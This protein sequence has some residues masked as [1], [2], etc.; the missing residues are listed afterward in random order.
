[1]FRFRWAVCQLDEIAKCINIKQLRTTLARLPKTL[2][3]TYERILC[4]IDEL[5]QEYALRI[6][7]WLVFSKRTFTIWQVAELVAIDTDEDAG[8]DEEE[9]LPDPQD[10]VTICS[11]LITIRDEYVYLAHYSVQEYLLSSRILKGQASFYA[12]ESSSANAA[13]AHGCLLYLQQRICDELLSLYTMRSRFPLA[14]YSAREWWA[15]A[16][17]V[18]D[19]QGGK[20]FT[21]ATKLFAN[22][23]GSSNSIRL[24]HPDLHASPRDSRYNELRS[25]WSGTEIITNLLYFAS[26]EGVNCIVRKLISDGADINVQFGEFGCPLQ[27]ALHFDRTTTFEILF[28]AGGDVHIRGGKHDTLLQTASFNGYERIVKLLIARQV[29]VNAHGGR[30]GSALQAACEKGHSTIAQLL[31]AAGADVNISWGL[32]TPLQTAASVGSFEILDKLLAAGA[33]PNGLDYHFHDYILF[34]AGSALRYASENGSEAMVTRLL[35][36]GAD[37]DQIEGYW[38]GTALQGAASRDHVSVVQLLLNAGA[39]VNLHIKDRA[40]PLEAAIHINSI[41]VVQILLSAGADVNPGAEC[42]CSALQA[43]VLVRSEEIT[44]MLLDAKADINAEIG[45]NGTALQAAAYTGSEEM[46]ELLLAAGADPTLVGNPSVN[47]SSP[48]QEACQQGLDTMVDRLLTAGAALNSHRISKKHEFSTQRLISSIEH[49]TSGPLVVAAVRGSMS[50]VEKLLAAGADVNGYGLCPTIGMSMGWAT[51]L[52]NAV[53]MGNAAIV[54]RLLAARADPNLPSKDAENWYPLHAAAA[55]LH[56]NLVLPLL[57]AGADPK[58]G[59]K[60]GNTLLH[61]TISASSIRRWDV[62]KEVPKLKERLE[63]I[64]ILLCNGVDINAVE[65]EWGTALTTATAFNIIPIVE[66]L[67]AA[68]AD[69][70][71]AGGK[72]LVETSELDYLGKSV[73]IENFTALQVAIGMGHQKIEALLRAADAKEPDVYLTSSEIRILKERVIPGDWG[74]TDHKHW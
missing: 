55:M 57:A 72:R 60:R 58:L 22:T 46:M 8:F 52:Y 37:V 63:I 11:S 47:P 51:S 39:D 45:Q 30:S 33:D 23:C 20:I 36:A 3:E 41:E 2:D 4:G 17:E 16:R 35:N 18:A 21:A 34:P 62:Y 38:D 44:K 65:E 66:K 31:L 68:G 27:G 9:V 29:D 43:A 10:A 6:L 54:E 13:I 49:D 67:I 42:V 19:D 59:G 25:D 7:R 69:L 24:Y 70:N 1:V 74:I 26:C 28:D 50:L 40:T 12:L 48:L 71:L 14:G 15:H 56:F 73:I 32:P 53:V 64:E 61:L 5:N